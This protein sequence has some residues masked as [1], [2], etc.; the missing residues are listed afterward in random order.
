MATV[1]MLANEVHKELATEDQA[2]REERVKNATHPK[3]ALKLNCQNAV[4]VI[5]ILVSLKHDT[6]YFILIIGRP[7]TK[8]AGGPSNQGFRNVPIQ[9]PP[10]NLPPA[11]DS[12]NSLDF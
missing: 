2:D 5:F 9:R 12:N 11:A 8:V 6:T 4:Q 10:V 1:K 7:K 3:A